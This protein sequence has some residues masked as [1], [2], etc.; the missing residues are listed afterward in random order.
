M[1]LIK[2]LNNLPN[3]GYV[4]E[5]NNRLCLAI[6]GGQSC[7]QIDEIQ[8]GQAIIDLNSKMLQLYNKC[9]LS[10]EE[11]ISLAKSMKKM[12]SLCDGRTEG[13]YSIKDQEQYIASL[14]DDAREDI[15]LQ[16]RM[17]KDCRKFYRVYC[18]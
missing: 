6:L 2:E 16:I 9:N 5:K 7:Q 4:F 3:F 18:S 10:D 8:F 12:Y 11:K 17:L 15:A 14:S 13:L 1:D